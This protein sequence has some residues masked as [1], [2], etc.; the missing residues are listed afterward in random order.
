MHVLREKGMHRHTIYA[1][2]Q[3]TFQNALRSE[4]EYPPQSIQ[5]RLD[6]WRGGE[7]LLH[8]ILAKGTSKAPFI[9][10]A[11]GAGWWWRDAGSGF[12]ERRGDGGG[13]VCVNTR[14]NY[15]YFDSTTRLKPNVSARLSEALKRGRVARCATMSSI[16]SCD[17]LGSVN[18]AATLRFVS[19]AMGR[20]TGYP[21]LL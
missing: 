14:E 21:H 4:L 8:E 10:L 13:G 17:V 18:V 1:F 19:L 15:L 5:S 2:T 12:G 16:T 6:K 3:P 7:C 11:A 9:Y 20:C